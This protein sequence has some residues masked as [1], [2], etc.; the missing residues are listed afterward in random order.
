MDARGRSTLESKSPSTIGSACLSSGLSTT[1]GDADGV[2]VGNPRSASVYFGFLPTLTA[3]LA[4][5]GVDGTDAL[6]EIAA[7]E[8]GRASWG[9]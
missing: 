6:G 3:G 9:C 2:Y 5:A 1:A 4:I 7:A 8:G